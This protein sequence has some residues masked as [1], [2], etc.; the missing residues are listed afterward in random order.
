MRGEDNG[1]AVALRKTQFRKAGFLGEMSQK[2]KTAEAECEN[3]QCMW[4]R[5]LE[6]VP[7]WEVKIW[8]SPHTTFTPWA[9]LQGSSKLVRINRQ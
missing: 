7:G 3:R 6:P 2:A 9:D 5:G 1:C 4:C 8:E